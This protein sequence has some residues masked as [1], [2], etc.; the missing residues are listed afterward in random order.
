MMDYGLLVS[1]ALAIAVP[2]A[3]ARWQGIQGFP[4][5]SRLTDLAIGPL[6]VG[7]VGGRLVTLVLDDP[8]ALGRVS[9]MMVI[10][11]GVEFWP[12]VILVAGVIA[13]SSR[14][15]WVNPTDRLSGLA[16]YALVGYGVYEGMCLFR[17]GCFGP[18]SG[19]GLRP[20]GMDTT[21]VPVGL[22]MGIALVAGAALL[23]FLLRRR[24]SAVVVVL[25]ATLI[26]ATVRSVASFWL[27]K[28][29]DALTRQHKLSI[30]VAGVA[31]V[32]LACRP[33]LHRGSGQKV[34][35]NQTPRAAPNPTTSESN[36][37]TQA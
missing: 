18:S 27:P 21:T 20:H 31:A 36:G 13:W 3:L 34:R 15:A 14:T 7:L 1:I 10:R 4:A 24:T 28:V 19:I 25:A 22:L 35:A 29:G 17:D 23:S 6:A 11:S 5:G 32:G 30:A 26:V 16:P 37:E 9:D 2:A 8:Q 33:M 12:G